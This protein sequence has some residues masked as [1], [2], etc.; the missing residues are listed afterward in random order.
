MNCRPFMRLRLAVWLSLA[1]GVWTCLPAAAQGPPTGTRSHSGQFVL[2]GSSTA[3]VLP[4]VP[5]PALTNSNS[6][7]LSPMLVPISCERIKQYLVNDLGVTS[8][9]QGKV[10]LSI[11]P[12]SLNDRGVFIT[13]DHYRKSWQYH[14]ALPTPIDRAIYVRAIVRVV[15]MEMISRNAG[16]G[17]T[18]PPAWLVE[19]LT[20]HI[21][22][23]REIEVSLS[24]PGSV[25][26]GVA[27]TPTVVSQTQNNPLQ[28]S[29]DVLKTSGTL[30]FEELSWPLRESLDGPVAPQYA[31][32]AHA[33]THHLLRLRNSKTCFRSWIET[34]PRYQNWQTSFFE[35]FRQHFQA[36][37]D[38]EKWWALQMTFLGRQDKG[39]SWARSE[40]ASA[41]RELLQVPARIHS[42]SNTLPTTRTV[43]LQTVLRE[44]NDEQQNS[45]LERK[46]RELEM[47]RL[48]TSPD[49]F[50]TLEKYHRVLLEALQK[51]KSAGGP[52]GIGRSS[53]LVAASVK[54]AFELDQ[55]DALEA[56]EA[57]NAPESRL[58][59]TDQQNATR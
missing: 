1:V 41:L 13:A 23:S 16:A 46:L 22:A 39:G 42:A 57:T 56:N 34:M 40:S 12:A 51:R 59:T 5:D 28:E 4:S 3:P 53:G 31:A 55:L 27:F 19:G 45:V 33:F 37:L 25:S 20:R 32:S 36:P 14:V 10:L 9:W 58:P 48:R 38:V 6:I 47:L 30:N 50:E 26:R 2:V 43:P 24:Q 8:P 54:A 18:E 29:M 15:L 11:R 35:A 7:D 17:A 52:F 49:Y 21:L 44:W